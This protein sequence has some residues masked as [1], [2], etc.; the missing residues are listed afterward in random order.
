MPTR[1][2]PEFFFIHEHFQRFLSTAHRR[3]EPWWY[4][5]PILAA[6]FLPW[7]FALP[8]AFAHGWNI[9]GRARETVE[10]RFALGF[11]LFVVLFFSASGS[12]LP[13]YILPA[14]PPLALVLDATWSRR[15][16]GSS[17]HDD[18]VIPWRVLLA[19]G[20]ARRSGARRGP[21]S[22]S[23]RRRWAITAPCPFSPRHRRPLPCGAGGAGRAPGHRHRSVLVVD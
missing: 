12:K 14:F 19:G 22:S 6:G 1:N 18:R 5:L 4:F 10:T 23:R 7:M 13:A 2:S 17:P 15:R 9:P 11:A 20:L 21:A 8:S 3:T 16:R